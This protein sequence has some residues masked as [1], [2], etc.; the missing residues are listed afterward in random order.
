MTTTTQR[1]ALPFK[2][3][4]YYMPLKE[5]LYFESNGNFIFAYFTNMDRQIIHSSLKEVETKMEK[6]RFCRIHHQYVIN[7]EHLTKFLKDDHQVVLLGND[8]KLP[9]SRSRESLLKEM[10]LLH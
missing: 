7:L 10:V 6:Y 1:I 2:H 4:F 8:I 5:I 9:V 3:G